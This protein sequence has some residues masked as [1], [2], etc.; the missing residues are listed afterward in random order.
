MGIFW[1]VCFRTDWV[2]YRVQKRCPLAT[3]CYNISEELVRIG[4]SLAPP[5]TCW[6]R[7]LGAGPVLLSAPSDPDSPEIGEPLS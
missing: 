2:N 7:N 5:Q 3:S 4:V 6:V 1:G